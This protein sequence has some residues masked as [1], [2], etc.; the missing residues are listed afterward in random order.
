MWQISVGSNRL[1]LGY[2]VLHADARENP[3]G[4]NRVMTPGVSE[5]GQ[6]CMGWEKE[7]LGF[8]RV[9]RDG[10]ARVPLFKVSSSPRT[11]SYFRVFSSPFFTKI[12]RFSPF[13][14]LLYSWP[15]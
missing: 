3:G 9:A 2:L 8:S 11:S 7:P 5:Q 12:S 4:K 14:G 1:G 6:T 13:L 10:G 15:P